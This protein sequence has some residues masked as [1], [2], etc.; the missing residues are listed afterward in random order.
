MQYS[1][2][3]EVFKYFLESVGLE[4]DLPKLSFVKPSYIP[5]DQYIELG[6]LTEV[7][8]V[9]K[10]AAN[11]TINFSPNITVIYGE[12]GTGKTGYGRILKALGFSYDRNNTIYSNVFGNP[13]QPK[14][15]TINYK[16]NGN[17]DTFTW[18]G[19]N[20]DQELE[21]ISVFNSDCVQISLDASRQLIVSPIGFHLF[22]LV[23]AELG[24][25]DSLLKAKKSEHPTQLSWIEN[26]HEGTHQHQ[27]IDS[28]SK[29][30][31]EKCL[32]ELSDFTLEH[33]KD[34]ERKETEISKL[35]KSLLQNEV[36]VRLQLNY[37]SFG[38]DDQDK[39][40]QPQKLQDYNQFL[41]DL[42]KL[43]SKIKWQR[44]QFFN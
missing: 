28:L 25:L 19:E 13:H 16:V 39:P 7:V 15:A 24:E 20:R 32:N 6:S 31:N 26:L 23:S 4:K 35:N 38:L 30:R 11:Q 42:K 34:L 21:N 17:P 9:N 27:F 40:L 12:N 3:E 37:E 1:D 2:R 14:S 33:E 41:T 36:E 43:L 29:D 18:N 8:G 10:L 5:S 22:N 44:I